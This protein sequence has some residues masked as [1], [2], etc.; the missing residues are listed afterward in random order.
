[1]Y[2]RGGCALVIALQEGFRQ[3]LKWNS[4]VVYIKPYLEEKV[5]EGPSSR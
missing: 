2:Y 3:C 5:P 4:F 1:M